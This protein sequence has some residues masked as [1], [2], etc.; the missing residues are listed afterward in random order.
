MRHNRNPP[1][2]IS[3][4][5]NMIKY[6]ITGRIVQRRSV[7]RESILDVCTNWTTKQCVESTTEVKV[8]MTATD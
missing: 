4:R 8:K 2:D 5:R 3:S 7:P 6:G 1:S